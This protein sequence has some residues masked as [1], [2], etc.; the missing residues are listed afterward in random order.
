[1]RHPFILAVLAVL[2]SG[3]CINV[4]DVVQVPETPDA[5]EPDTPVEDSGTPDASVPDSGL[6]DSG[7]QDLAV[8]LRTSRSITNGDVHLTVTLSGAAPDE[9]ELLVDGAAVATLTPPY[10]LRWSTQS[11][12]EGEHVL[13]AR[14]TLGGRR[15]TSGSRTLVVD[16]T[17]PRL[18]SQ[19]PQTGAR[20]V[21]V[22]QTVQASF[23]EPL[24]VSTV[25]ADSAKLV[26]EAGTVASEVSLSTEGTLLTLRPVAPLPVDATVAVSFESTVVDLAGNSVQPLEPAWEWTVPGYLPLGE[27]LS[28]SPIE[29]SEVRGASLQIDET[30]Q[31]VVAWLDGTSLDPYGVR[32]K[33]WNGSDWEQLGD[34]LQAASG[35]VFGSFCSLEADGSGRL[36]VAWDEGSGSS[37]PT[38]RVRRWDGTTWE[39]VGNSV[40]PK[41]QQAG[42]DLIS[43]RV[44][45]QSRPVLAFREA[46]QSSQ[47]VSVW[48]WDGSAWGMLGGALKVNST[49]NVSGVQ[50]GVGP[51]GNPV[52]AWSES[53]SG[54]IAAH[55]RRWSGS[56]WESIP[57]PA[58]TF[59]GN[60]TVDDSGAPILEVES[61]DGT[62]Q[63][64]RLWRWNGS[65]WGALGGPIGIY[66]G[67]TD[68]G[69]AALIFD[70]QGRLTV[71]VTEAEV[72]G[73]PQ[74]LYLRRWN[75]G[76]WESVGSLLRA[77][78]GFTPVGAARFG[79]DASGQPILARVEQTETMPYMRRIYVYRPNN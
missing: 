53:N 30:G 48:R 38:I 21:S 64:A 67:A 74:V 51:D 55:M 71:L 72:A 10:E 4:P 18:V 43:F 20:T 2:L 5:G 11:I 26:S 54:S 62:A 28:V 24:D 58:Q 12:E 45:Q 76:A 36:F 31:P 77:R 3:A 17:P 40:G 65:S 13:A 75:A 47:V 63:S 39:A 73:G 61:W 29:T 78:V 34:V 56:A 60:L 59:P 44:S 16:R 37:G 46:N 35:H 42:M 32:V 23:S 66:P 79:L 50:L 15:F 8:E 19:S 27:P 22:H 57:M 7:T 25:S 68:S 52:V 69:V 9:V 49:W 6:P 33:R 70:A 1:M 14:A 41:L